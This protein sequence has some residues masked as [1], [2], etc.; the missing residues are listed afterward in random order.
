M[1]P[2]IQIAPEPALSQGP[3]RGPDCWKCQFLK[4]TYLRETPYSCAF[5]G[6]RSQWLPSL[7]VLRADGDFCRGFQPKSPKP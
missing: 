2:S 3:E 1:R 7:E 6:F 5:M 4:I